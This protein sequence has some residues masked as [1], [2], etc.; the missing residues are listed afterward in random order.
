MEFAWYTYAHERY[1]PSFLI[2]GNDHGAPEKAFETSAH[3][4]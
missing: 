4:L 2:T 1:A 3:F